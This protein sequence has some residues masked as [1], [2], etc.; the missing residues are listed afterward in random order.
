VWLAPNLYHFARR[1]GSK[2]DAAETYESESKVNAADHR[3]SCQ[4]GPD[5]RKIGAPIQDRLRK[6][7]KMRR[8][9]RDLHQVLQ[10][11]WH[12]LHRGRTATAYVR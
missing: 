9:A 11:D 3:H 1:S 6:G 12:A 7:H 10:P 8:R 4:Q 2:D 5:D